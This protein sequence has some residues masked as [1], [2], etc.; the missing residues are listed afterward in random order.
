M[1]QPRYGEMAG[2]HKTVRDIWRSRNDELPDMPMLDS[3]RCDNDWERHE[4]LERMVD[5]KKIVDATLKA[6]RP[7]H[8]IAL[9]M[10]FIQGKSYA[11]VGRA[12]NIS[13]KEAGKLGAEARTYFAWQMLK[14]N[15]SIF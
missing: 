4:S 10:H 7:S 8:R 2:C 15:L 6:M 11:E 12:L 9:T 13:Q 14:L 5:A 1:R 3:T